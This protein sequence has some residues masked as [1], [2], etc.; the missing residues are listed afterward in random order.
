MGKTC[1]DCGIEVK[2]WTDR[3]HFRGNK[4]KGVFFEVGIFNY[5]W[6]SN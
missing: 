2:T 3:M 6:N 5:F 1:L 4:I